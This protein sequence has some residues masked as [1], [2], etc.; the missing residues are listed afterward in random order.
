MKLYLRE[1]RSEIADR[2]AEVV[3]LQGFWTR[4]NEFE[5]SMNDAGLTV[6]YMDSE[7]ADI[8][9][10]DSEEYC[11]VV[12]NRGGNSFTIGKIRC[13]DEDG[14]SFWYE[15]DD[16]EEGL[17]EYVD[18][19]Y[20]QYRVWYRPFDY[21]DEED[22][23]DVYATDTKD[24]RYRGNS[25]GYVTDVEYLGKDTVEESYISEGYDPSDDLADIWDFVKEQEYDSA[26]TSQN[27]L[28]G[29][30]KAVTELLEPGTINLDYGGGR[31]DQAVEWL[32]QVEV[33]N[34][35]FDPFNRSQEHNREVLDILRE[36]GGADSCTCC[37]VL[38]VIDGDKAKITALKNIK[39]L[40]KNGGKVYIQ[41]YEGSDKV[42]VQNDKGKTVKRPSGVGKTTTK[43]WQENKETKAY[44]PIVKQVFSDATYKNIKGVPMIVCTA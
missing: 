25:Y 37:N 18:N 42:E 19:D 44:L 20:E 16:L 14:N 43:G 41:T 10:P 5:E 39:R 23:V 12:F 2:I 24:A 7:S 15:E 31:Y 13:F 4:D 9:D 34:L 8:S 28:P 26:A 36:A 33:M 11:R 29:G 35:V 6:D 17:N 1:S 21:P 32:K 30:V 40:V 3:G 22:Y 27:Q 38:N